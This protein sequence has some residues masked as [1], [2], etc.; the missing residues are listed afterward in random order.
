MLWTK[1]LISKIA[2]GVAILIVIGFI[3]WKIRG[4]STYTIE[5]IKNGAPGSLEYSFYSNLSTCQN[6]FTETTLGSVVAHE[7]ISCTGI[8]VTVGT[9][10]PH[11]YVQ[12]DTIYVQGV[13]SDGTTM[14]IT[15][16][17]NTTSTPV[18]VATVTDS[19]TFT[20]TAVNGSCSAAGS[21]TITQNG[22]SWKSGNSDVNDRNN[23]RDVCISSNVSTYMDGKCKWA[24]NAKPTDNDS[25]AN[26]EQIA[27]Y[28]T[29]AT[30]VNSDLGIIKDAYANL[31]LTAPTVA[32]AAKASQEQ[33]KSAREAD[34]TAATRKYLNTV[35]DGFYAQTTGTDGNPATGQVDGFPNT[36]YNS[37]TNRITETTGRIGFNP[38]LVTDTNIIAWANY[39]SA[40]D[41]AGNF[42]G[43]APL[44]TGSTLYDLE[45]PNT[46][47]TLFPGMKNW[48][49]A[50]DVGPGTVTRSG[51]FNAL[52][53]T[54]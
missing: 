39:A 38:S 27:A 52:M 43:S 15:K 31:L 5:S 35:C 17:Y 2:I 11:Q 6:T 21:P 1:K 26:G 41:A 48:Q 47:G 24:G 9:L 23:T 37:Y 34:F 36:P 45:K 3:I 16:G 18:S 25:G 51:T 29:Y 10:L 7:S 8:T 14:L 32:T 12:G 30:G 44:V 40:R 54:A 20:Y 42:T 33:I 22:Y 46:A 4:K 13:S 28:N 19:H 53:R 49:I 50:Q